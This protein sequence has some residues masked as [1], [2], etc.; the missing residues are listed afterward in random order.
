MRA[1][2]VDHWFEMFATLDCPSV[3]KQIRVVP[4]MA[5]AALAGH[6]CWLCAPRP[7]PLFR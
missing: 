5:V 2:Q 4:P 7:W 1:S 6:M 3:S